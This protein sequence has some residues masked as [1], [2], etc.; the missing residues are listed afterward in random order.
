MVQQALDADF[1]C[2]KLV[3]LLWARSSPKLSNSGSV[4]S[5]VRVC[6]NCMRVSSSC[7]V[8]TDI[9]G[10]SSEI[11]EESLFERFWCKYRFRAIVKRYAFTDSIRVQ[12]L[13]KVSDVISFASSGSL[14]SHKEKRYTSSAYCLYDSRKLVVSLLM[15]IQYPWS[16]IKVHVKI[17]I[18]QRMYISTR[19]SSKKAESFQ[20]QPFLAAEGNTYWPPYEKTPVSKTTMTLIL[21]VISKTA[22]VWAC[23]RLLGVISP[24]SCFDRLSMTQCDWFN[25][26]DRS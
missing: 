25:F 19:I 22:S 14:E 16:R 21:E 13:T 12:A 8:W 9:S 18:F 23:R 26:W 5:M 15:Y 1:K 2:I 20:N 4:W 6:S 24:I 3:H 7:S 11:G 17:E 10:S